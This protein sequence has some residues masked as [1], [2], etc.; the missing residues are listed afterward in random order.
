MK[1]LINFFLLITILVLLGAV[2]ISV[3]ELNE[4]CVPTCS[5]V[6]LK[7]NEASLKEC[8]KEDYNCQWYFMQT[9]IKMGNYPYL[10]FPKYPKHYKKKFQEGNF[11]AF[12]NRKGGASLTNVAYSSR[13]NSRIHL[14]LLKLSCMLDDPDGLLDLIELEENDTVV[15]GSVESGSSEKLVIYLEE[16]DTETGEATFH[17]SVK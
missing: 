8:L 4:R 10:L 2:S 6:D 11:L 16:L 1:R 15:I 12:Q 9:R 5:P 17:I 14:R 13:I 3:A 7:L